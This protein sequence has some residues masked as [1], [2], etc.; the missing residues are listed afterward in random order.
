MNISEILSTTGSI[1][2]YGGI[3]GASL[4]I[5]LMIIFLPIFSSE[6]KRINKKINKDFNEKE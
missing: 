5:L 4:S 6:K 1:F 3:A 2:F